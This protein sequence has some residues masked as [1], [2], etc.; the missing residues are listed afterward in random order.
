[1]TMSGD[2]ITSRKSAGLAVAL[3]VAAVVACCCNRGAFPSSGA[4]SPAAGPGLQNAP[5]TNTIVSASRFTFVADPAAGEGMYNLTLPLS[6]ISTMVPVLTVEEHLV[7]H[8]AVPAL[9]FLKAWASKHADPAR[10]AGT[11]PSGP[12]GA[13]A[14]VAATTAAAAADRRRRSAADEKAADSAAADGRGCTCSG[15]GASAS[16]A[17]GCFWPAPTTAML[18]LEG[19]NA[20]A[21]GDVYDLFV[22]NES[23]GQQVAVEAAEVVADAGASAASA[24]AVFRLRIEAQPDF[25]PGNNKRARRPRHVWQQARRGAR[26]LSQSC[27]P[28]GCVPPCMRPDQSLR[29]HTQTEMIFSVLFRLFCNRRLQ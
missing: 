11:F 13:A 22:I 23:H 27:A 28:V 5:L 9:P 26:C 20:A 14:I 17:S 1:M 18:V 16:S 25:I 21:V 24:V 6:A 12:S 15:R 8:E 2:I 19:G 7:R 4:S 10:P 3:A 29:N